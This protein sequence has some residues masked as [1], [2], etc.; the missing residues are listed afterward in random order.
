MRLELI[1]EH[2]RDLALR[3]LR[4]ARE[5]GELGLVAEPRLA[6]EELVGG[7]DAPLGDRGADVGDDA[8]DLACARSSAARTRSAC[9][10]IAEN[11]RSNEK[12]TLV[13]MQARNMSQSMALRM[14]RRVPCR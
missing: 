1:V 13:A 2:L 3:G 14:T 10:K 7:G 5:A 12:N 11:S 4:L 6:A 8:G 9:G